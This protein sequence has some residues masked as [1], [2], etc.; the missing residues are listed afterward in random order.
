MAD[1][2][3]FELEL[4]P[5][6]YLREGKEH[7]LVVPA[8]IANWGFAR[9]LEL[10]LEG[11]NLVTLDGAPGQPRQ[12]L[13]DTQLNVKWVMREGTLQEQAGPSVAS[14]W[15]ILLPETGER[16]FGAEL[17]TIVSMRWPALTL[18]ANGAA[19]LTRERT[20]GLFGGLIA[21]GPLAWTV[22]PVAELFVDREA[23][24]VR[25]L[26]A[27]AGAIWRWRPSLIFDGALR[28]ASTGDGAS[29][30]RTLEVRAGLTWAF[31]L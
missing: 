30:V 28:I 25:E 22:R 4:G 5:V 12:Q 31:S 19:A 8:L 6:G 23:R 18:H 9:H 13:V 14:E 3:G 29:G 2:G 16:R 27:L 17:A 11:R 21:E 26:S 15:T 7:A 1:L 20:L 24:D 10:V